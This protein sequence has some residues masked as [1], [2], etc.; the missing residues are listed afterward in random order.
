MI[1]MV[2]SAVRRGLLGML[3]LPRVIDVHRQVMRFEVARDFWTLSVLGK[4]SFEMF[5][6]I[7]IQS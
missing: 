6:N 1:T 3:L 5:L 2:T 4:V 7:T